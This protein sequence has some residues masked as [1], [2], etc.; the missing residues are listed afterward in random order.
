MEQL[1]QQLD[2]LRVQEDLN[3]MEQLREQLDALQVQ[4]DLMSA[5]VDFLFDRDIGNNFVWEIVDNKVVIKGTIAQQMKEAR[6]AALAQ[7]EEE[8]RR[9]TEK[10]SSTP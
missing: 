9:R 4:V 5:K 2:A 3:Y 8:F 10:K 1:R 7:V 6:R